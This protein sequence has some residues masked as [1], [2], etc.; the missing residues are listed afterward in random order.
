MQM[1]TCNCPY[2]GNYVESEMC[3]DS[4]LGG[5]W[6]QGLSVAVPCI[7]CACQINQVVLKPN[8]TAPDAGG[9]TVGTQNFC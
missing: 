5:G 3:T 2:S 1:T 9:V 6:R 4:G 7:F 8:Q